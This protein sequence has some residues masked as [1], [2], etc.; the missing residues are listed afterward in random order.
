MDGMLQF[1]QAIPNLAPVVAD[2][3]AEN[4]DWPGS[5]KIAE[6]IR[7]TMPP[8]VLEANGGA[9]QIAMKLN[10]AMQQLQQSEQMIQM[11]KQALDQATQELETKESEFANK[12]DVE[13]LKA[14]A[15]IQ[16]ALIRQETDLAKTKAD[17]WASIRKPVSKGA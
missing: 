14:D 12:I 3:I 16:V 13:Q 8:E 6:R 15:N 1:I 7:A 9:E 4:S 17:L 2:L 5:T 11:L 10:Q